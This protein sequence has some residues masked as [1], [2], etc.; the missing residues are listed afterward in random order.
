MTG[1]GVSVAGGCT[2][3]GEEPTATAGGIGAAAADA[4]TA[5]GCPGADEALAVVDTVFA[6]Y[7]SRRLCIVGR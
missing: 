3:E 4:A 7:F 1:A 6:L 2:P 5:E